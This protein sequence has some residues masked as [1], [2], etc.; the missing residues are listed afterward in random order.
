MDLN[1]LIVA[2]YLD[3]RV[4]KGMTRDFSPNRPGFH[5]E[6]EGGEIL[7]L[8]LRQLK[9]VFFVRSHE[10]DPARQDVRGF[11]QGPPETAQGRKIAV[12]FRDGEFLCGYTLSWSPDREG[13]F[14]F[15]ADPGSNN[16][17][18]YI[19]CTSTDEVKAGPQAEALA[20]RVL[21][22]ARARGAGAPPP[23]ATAASAWPSSTM[24]RPSGATARP[25]SSFR[26]PSGAMNNPQGTTLGPR[27]SPPGPHPPERDP[28]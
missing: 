2:R 21:A 16:Q 10:G 19:L 6:I 3:G 20:E 8:R 5:V 25:S 14:L 11:V 23:G 26:R 18:V 13:F 1:N 15:P 27:P 7:E 24:P 4:L 28:A 22:E 9:A 12:R 17:R